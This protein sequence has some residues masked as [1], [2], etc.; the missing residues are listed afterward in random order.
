MNQINKNPLIIKMFIISLILL[1]GF[2][3]IM[4]YSASNKISLE[5]TGDS[6]F[7]FLQH[8]KRL[9]ISILIFLTFLF[10]DYKKLSK[11]VI[12]FFFI[13]L[14]IVIY[15]I[16]IKV[17]NGHSFPARWFSI[18]SISIQTS[19]VVRLFL[20]IFVTNYI[21]KRKSKMTD[22]K[23][24]FL[25][26]FIVIIILI[27]LIAVQPDF[28]S[29]VILYFICMIL[30]YVGG[31]KVLHIFG[32]SS[33]MAILGLGYVRFSPYRWQRIL[34][35]FDSSN[36]KEDAYQIHQSLVSLSNGGF[37]GQ[38]LGKSMGKNLFLPEANTDFIF[39]IIG[40]EFGFLGATII[41]G[42]FFLLFYTMNK[43]AKKITNPFGQL[44]VFSTALSLIIYALF[45]MA[46]C[47]G[48]GP[49]TG[50]PMP[51]VSY[52]GSQLLINGALLGIVFN[53]YLQERKKIEL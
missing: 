44:I 15:P 13:T 43:L 38:G 46:V 45:N 25:P 20:I 50:L 18:G 19:E 14:A 32:V 34:T 3:V 10:I 40:E 51:F 7:Y 12:V 9:L 52:S 1:I 41:V 37:W 22:F 30:L 6:T 2:G 21:A 17:T 47:S 29:S 11:A 27:S 36:I 42:L 31:A 8:L 5:Q 49:V 39:S 35:F 23:Q 53:I 26:V 4:Q 33:I 16:I 24:D 28:S 48:I